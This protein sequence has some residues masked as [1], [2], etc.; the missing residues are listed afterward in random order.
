MIEHKQ[1]I[2][3]GLDAKEG[4][5][6]WHS[7]IYHTDE[8]EL[9]Q[10]YKCGGTLISSTAVLTAAHC[11]YD[12]GRPII[13]ERVIVH[14]GKYDLALASMNTQQFKAHRLFIHDG[15]KQNKL[16]DD[17]ALVRL[18]TEATF[19]AYVKPICLWDARRWALSEVVNKTGIVVGWGLNER[20]HFSKQLSQASLPVVDPVDCLTSNADFFASFITKKTFCAGYRN[21]K[22][23]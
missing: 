20:I 23:F 17:I 19:T 6:P 18:A 3:N 1:L 13:A 4:D 12:F 16:L 15:Y 21:G 10:S 7:A 5:W 9:A 11:L 14:T 22:C 8:N 2:T